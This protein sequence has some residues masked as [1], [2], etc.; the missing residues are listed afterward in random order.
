MGVCEGEWYLYL[1]IIC[2]VNRDIRP[3]KHDTTKHTGTHTHARTQAHKHTHTNMTHTIT[4]KHTHTNTANG[5]TIHNDPWSSSLP[6]AVTLCC[7]LPPPHLIVCE[8]RWYPVCSCR[9][10]ITLPHVTS[11]V[12]LSSSHQ[13]SNKATK[14]QSNK[15]MIQS[16]VSSESCTIR[17]TKYKGDLKKHTHTHIHTR[18]CVCG[19]L[20]SSVTT[21]DMHHR[22]SESFVLCHEPLQAKIVGSI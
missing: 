3:P 19:G 6:W 4:S 12:V 22:E 13:H 1:Y 21:Q 16:T 7:P 15:A 17:Y 9:S 11:T 10:L 20:C 18:R 8:C 5:L 2:S 14:Q